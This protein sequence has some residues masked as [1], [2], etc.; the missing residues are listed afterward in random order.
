MCVDVDNLDMVAPSA[1]RPF[2]Q[3]LTS[4]SP[5]RSWIRDVDSRAVARRRRVM[6]RARAGEQLTPTNE[7][8][9][10]NEH[11]YT[12]KQLSGINPTA[13]TQR[14]KELNKTYINLS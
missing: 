5:P 9:K 6:P 10:L 4:S 8:M 14:A 3:P 2:F 12:N 11:H 13:L 1:R 7:K